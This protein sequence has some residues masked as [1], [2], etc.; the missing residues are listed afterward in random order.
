M[1]DVL[2]R[3][4]TWPA[5]ALATALVWGLLPLWLIL[6]FVADRLRARS[7]LLRTLLFAATYLAAELAGLA[8]GLAIWPLGAIH[9]SGDAARYRALQ[10]AWIGVLWSAAV[11][12]YGLTVQ[13]E[14]R[15]GGLRG[16]VVVL[17]RHTSMADTALAARFVARPHGLALRYVLKAE[18]LW[19]P[20]LDLVGQR[21]P[22]AFVRRDA[23]EGS[24]EARRVAELAAGLDAW[25]GVVIYPEGT[26][27]SRT[28]RMLA[29]QR[30]AKRDPALLPRAERLRH[31][32]PPRPGGVLALLDAV[33]GDVVVL[34]HTGLEGASDLR[35]VLDGAL[36]GRTI[37]I[38]L[39]R[40]EPKD[41]PR[42]DGARME[43]VWDRWEALDDWVER[44]GSP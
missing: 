35:A 37:R 40:H 43:W 12:I 28:R 10:A 34:G 24:G 19:D 8:V 6:A 4:I 1:S 7:A 2:R 31:L 15:T 18:L 11:R 32:L 13:V 44:S 39:W 21:L 25:E 42:A 27:F 41:R 23:A 22:N 26:R 9:P 16:P 30:L 38:A 36:V 3:L 17:V 20:C 5:L 29:L 33:G 14:D